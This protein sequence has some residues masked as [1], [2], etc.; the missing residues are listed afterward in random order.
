[1]D[2]NPAGAG[3]H[4]VFV[5]L[6]VPVVGPNGGREGALLLRVMRGMARKRPII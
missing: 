4:A 1:M 2:V 5:G 6:E 3:L